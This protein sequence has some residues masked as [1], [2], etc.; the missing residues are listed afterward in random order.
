MSELADIR[1]EIDRIDAEVTRLLEKRMTLALRA[2][3][4]KKKTGKPVRDEKR[5]EEILSGIEKRAERAFVPALQAVYDT[6]FSEC[7]KLEQLK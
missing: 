3:E 4:E 5:E 2:G 6:L 1:K 7:V